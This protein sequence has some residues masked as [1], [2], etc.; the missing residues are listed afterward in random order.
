MQV[1]ATTSHHCVFVATAPT[2]LAWTARVTQELL[3][4]FE[5]HK[6]HFKSELSFRRCSICLFSCYRLHDQ[7]ISRL[8]GDITVTKYSN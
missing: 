2:D 5:T 7:Q 4:I 6:H 1:V 3:E 8:S